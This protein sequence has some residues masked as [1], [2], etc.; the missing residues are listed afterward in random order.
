M[1]QD[2]GPEVISK[3]ACFK[4]WTGSKGKKMVVHNA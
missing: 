3:L 2:Y 4:W 1:L